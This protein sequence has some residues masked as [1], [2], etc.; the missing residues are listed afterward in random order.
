MW[1]WAKKGI[2]GLSKAAWADLA[3]PSLLTVL[4]GFG[5]GLV[6]LVNG[7]LHWN[8][9]L[10]LPISGFLLGQ[11]FGLVQLQ[12]VRALDARLSMPMLL[13]L[14]VSGVAGYLATDYGLYSSM[15]VPI[16]GAPGMADGRY[17]LP[18]LMSFAG[19][20]EMQFG[21]A[22]DPALGGSPM[23]MRLSFISDL[24]GCFVGTVVCLGIGKSRL[25]Y[26]RP[27]DRYH[28]QHRRQ[29]LV[30]TDDVGVVENVL[31]RM[32]TFVTEGRYRDLVKHLDDVEAG[33][34]TLSGTTMVVAEHFFCPSCG[35]RILHGSV[36]ARSGR[37]E[38][39]EI[40]G[41]SFRV[42]SK[43]ARDRLTSVS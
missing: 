7:H 13:F 37:Y 11:G 31:H 22:L 39:S 43:K 9:W 26:C 10:V 20:L 12:I 6:P 35:R 8:L 4:L 40:A 36:H 27:C 19:F 16:Q 41:L 18:A 30:L 15:V 1:A 24:V 38:W 5:L 28:R 14:G 23:G 25:G 3:I 32:T 17:P 29:E 33:E 21:G 34:T 42:K 2:S